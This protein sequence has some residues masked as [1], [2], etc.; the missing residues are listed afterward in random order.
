MMDETAWNSPARL[1]TLG[2]VA[3]LCGGSSA[4]RKIS[5]QSGAAVCA[6]LQE[7]GVDVVRI[8]PAENFADA[9][10][11]A[12]PQLAFI[13]LHGRGGED[14]SMQGYL[15]TAGI[16]YTGSG[17]LGSALAMDKWRSKQIWQ[18]CGLPVPTGRLLTAETDWPALGAELGY[19]LF[20][21][22]VHEGSSIGMSR[23]TDAAGLEAA[24]REAA[25]YDSV[26]LAEQFVQGGEYTVGIVD[27]R[28]LPTLRLETPRDFYDYDA[29]YLTNDTRYLFPAGLSVSE[30][31]EIA[32]LAMRAFV[33]LGCSGWGR[34]DIMRNADGAFRLLEVN[35]VPGL[36][37]HSLVP[38]AAGHAGISFAELIVRILSAAEGAS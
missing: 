32:D 24:W 25:R 33:A 7:L 6:A 29:K 22:P 18:A 2:R 14:G 30:E 28:A 4:E 34:V 17:V 21:K 12:A 8:D 15:Q 20:V 3:V 31:I 23:V 27:G 5:L 35:T 16:P 38:M 26:I 36:T 11:S 9:L 10:R 19:P 1:A 37:D 13:A